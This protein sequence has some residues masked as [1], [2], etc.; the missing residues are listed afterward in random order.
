MGTVER[1]TFIFMSTK[2]LLH[3]PLCSHLDLF[4]PSVST[5]SFPPPSCKACCWPCPPVSTAIRR[6]LLIIVDYRVIGLSWWDHPVALQSKSSKRKQ[7]DRAGEK[8]LE[9]LKALHHDD[10]V[11]T[12][13]QTKTSHSTLT[14][15]HW[16]VSCCAQLKCF[17][18]GQ[19][20]KCAS[21][22]R[23]KKM[24][25][26]YNTLQKVGTQ[27]TWQSHEDIFSMK[28]MEYET[29]S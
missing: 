8:S 22:T 26:I 10:T 15:K 12:A 25:C 28:L 17:W 3:L 19:K 24:L 5:S 6:E 23:V 13:E 16:T 29:C 9:R 20:S 14:D 11:I 27:A 21:V 2:S 4:K 7:L 1:I 18:Q